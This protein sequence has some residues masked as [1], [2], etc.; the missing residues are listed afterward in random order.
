[1]GGNTWSMRFKDL[2][3]CN[4]T[5]L[6]PKDVYEAFWWH[7]LEPGVHYVHMDTLD[8]DSTPERLK[9]FLEVRSEGIC[10]LCL[11]PATA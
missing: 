6:V 10:S 9:T 11:H 8:G 3:L 5:V 7:L 1:M 2:F 4:S